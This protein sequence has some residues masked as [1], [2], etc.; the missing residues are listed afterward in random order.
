MCLYIRC[1]SK[2]FDQ[3][4]DLLLITWFWE[5]KMGEKDFMINQIL[6]SSSV[7]HKINKRTLSWIVDQIQNLFLLA[8][9]SETWILRILSKE[10]I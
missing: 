1:C 4:D 6:L 8:M 5:L 2:V 7:S 9:I 3:T 10:E